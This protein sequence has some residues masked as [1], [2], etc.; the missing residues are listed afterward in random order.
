MSAP[1][2][3]DS[4]DEKAVALYQRIMEVNRQAAEHAVM[5]AE[6]HL[7]STKRQQN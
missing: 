1:N 7:N 5:L 2:C 3:S 4:A 6:A